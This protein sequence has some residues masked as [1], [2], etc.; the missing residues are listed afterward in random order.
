MTSAELIADLEQ[1]LQHSIRD[2]AERRR[3]IARLEVEVADMRRRQ[4]AILERR[5]A[6]TDTPDDVLDYAVSEREIRR[7]EEDLAAARAKEARITGNLYRTREQLEVTRRRWRREQDER[8]LEALVERTREIE[9]ALLS[10]VLEL[11][12]RCKRQGRPLHHVYRPADA[13]GEL[14]NQGGVSHRHRVE[15][16]LAQVN[17]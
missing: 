12:E 14:V 8:Q 4:H 11:Q 17:R 7:L 1:R 2:A 10:A 9:Q 13:L 3:E 16:R 6:G 15:T 5:R